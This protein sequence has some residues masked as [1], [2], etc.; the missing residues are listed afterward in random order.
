MLKMSKSINMKNNRL[1]LLIYGARQ[2]G[3]TYSIKAFAKE[4]YEK[5]VYVNFDTDMVIGAYFGDNISPEYIV[6]ILEEYYQ[7]KIVPGETL[8]F[9]IKTMYPMN[10]EEYLLA[11]SEDLLLKSINIG[12]EHNKPLPK[13]LHSRGLSF[14]KDYVI[15]GGMPAVVGNS[16]NKFASVE[17]EM[18]RNLILQSYTSDMAKYTTA[19][20][21]IKTRS[22]YDSLPAQLAKENKK[23]QYKVIKSGARASMF[24]D[25]IDWLIHAGVVLKC[26]RITEGLAPIKAYE[27]ISGFKLYSNDIGLLCQQAGLTRYSIEQ[28]V[29][30]QFLGGVTENY[31]ACEL[32]NQGYLLFY[33]ESKG[34]AE[35]D[36]IISI[37]G[38][39]IPVDVKSG[40]NNRSRSLN[41]F[42]KKYKPPFSVRIS[43]KNFGFENNI[44]LVP[45]YAVYCMNKMVI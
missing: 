5:S 13:A 31:V 4:Y 34:S 9:M 18:L 44:K 6:P 36:F 15:T 40:K 35:V 21:N 23:F 45:L 28:S 42:V 29:T 8:L 24:G 25:S 2:V 32:V 19:A 14:Y 3:K 17:D 11:R 30:N 20:E 22:A 27:D 41:E 39:P 33:W 43:E 37:Q 38:I 16:I 7:I 10:F 1:P 26:G 12:F